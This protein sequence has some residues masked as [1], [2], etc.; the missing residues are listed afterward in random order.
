MMISFGLVNKSFFYLIKIISTKRV[1]IC[2][3]EKRG[4]KLFQFFCGHQSCER[5]STKSKMLEH[6]TI[7]VQIKESKSGD[8][9][10]VEKNLFYFVV[11]STRYVEI[12]V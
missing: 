2:V 5:R 8:H 1:E 6:P 10:E 9:L 7:L 3:K 12:C 11:I 4:H